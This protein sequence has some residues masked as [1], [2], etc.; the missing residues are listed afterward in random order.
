MARSA[1]S[2]VRMIEE[3]RLVA[4]KTAEA[5]SESR[6]SA[7]EGTQAAAEVTETMDAIAKSSSAVSETMNRLVSKSEQIGGIVETING[8]A[9]QTDMLA[10]NAA[11]EA[12]RAGEHGRGFAVVAEEVRRLAERSQ[13]AAGEIRTIIEEIHD[14]TESAVNV[15]SKGAERTREGAA[16]VERARNSS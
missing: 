6:R 4:E 8:I 12:A 13:R 9:G 11:I 5:A 16:V 3:A 7:N 14:E 2:Q 15:V 10:L 1:E